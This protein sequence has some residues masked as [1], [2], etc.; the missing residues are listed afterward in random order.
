[1]RG[2]NALG[3]LLDISMRE[4]LR[5]MCQQLPDAEHLRHLLGEPKKCLP[6]HYFSNNYYVL[7]CKWIVFSTWLR[8]WQ[9]M[10]VVKGMWYTK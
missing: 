7:E 1:M 6:K 3:Q 4:V 2:D 8:K 9:Q 5:L 10:E